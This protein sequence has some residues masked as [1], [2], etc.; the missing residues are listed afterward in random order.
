MARLSI[1]ETY[2]LGELFR[3]HAPVVRGIAYRVLRDPSEADDMTQDVFLL[4][5]RLCKNFDSSRGSARSWIFQMTYRRAIS[6]RRYLVARHF[7]THLSFS[8]ETSDLNQEEML[9]KANLGDSVVEELQKQQ[10]IACWFRHLSPNQQQTLRLFFF[11][12]YSFEEIGA[13]L[14][15]TVGAVRNHYYRGLERLR[16]HLFGDNPRKFDNVQHTQSSE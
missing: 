10:T 7:Y 1:G 15:Q 3:R 11:E 5:H 16:N 12:G 13:N 8:D 9:T 4:I 2:V 14:G 6:R